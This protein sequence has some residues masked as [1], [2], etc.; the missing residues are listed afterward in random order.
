MGR[1]GRTH[2]YFRSDSS[3]EGR[4]HDRFSSTSSNE[5]R[6][7]DLFSSTSSNGGRAHDHF[8]ST[9]SSG[10]RAHDHSVVRLPMTDLLD[11]PVKRGR[12][13]RKLVLTWHTSLSRGVGGRPN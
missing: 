4:A 13:R 5:G 2:D 7:H 3:N 11:L 6:A 10:G 8:S 1:E 12:S 9:S